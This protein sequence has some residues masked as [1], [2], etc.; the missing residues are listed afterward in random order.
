MCDRQDYRSIEIGPSRDRRASNLEDY[1]RAI[2]LEVRAMHLRDGRRRERYRIESI[3]KFFERPAEV[4]L[5]DLTNLADAERTNVLL[6]H[7][8]L[9][10]NLGREQIGPRAHDLA[11]LDERRAKT[12]K[13]DAN[14][15]PKRS[16]RDATV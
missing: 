9:A 13:C 14:R 7:D 5:D 16:Q 15:S 3:E 2:P 1:V 10:D 12:L 8:Q 6:Q 4:F 11:D